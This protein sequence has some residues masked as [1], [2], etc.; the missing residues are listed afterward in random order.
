[1][2]L[3]IQKL[4]PAPLTVALAA[5]ALATLAACQTSRNLMGQLT[6][7]TPAALKKPAPHPLND[8][9]VLL[10]RW[11]DASPAGQA[12]LLDAAEQDYRADSGDRQ[13][14][15]LALLLGEPGGGTPPAD[16]PRA[17]SLLQGLLADP[18]STLSPGEQT[19]ARF[20]LVLITRQLTLQ[21]ENSTLRTTGTQR[22]A[23]LNRRLRTTTQLNVSLARQLGEA[24]AK[25]AAIA[26]IEKSLEGR[27]GTEARPK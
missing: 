23:D 19:L 9:L 12:E 17:Q 3:E 4:R 18:D 11:L 6:Q 7:H 20:E 26:N 2:P 27:L 16:L 25:L 10:R 22:L 5:L 15:R 14:L 1:M 24:K 13:T 8:D 21:T